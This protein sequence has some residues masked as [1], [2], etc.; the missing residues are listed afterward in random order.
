M[1]LFAKGEKIWEDQHDFAPGTVYA[2]KIEVAET[3]SPDELKVVVLKEDQRELISWQMDK[4]DSADIPEPA[5]AALEPEQIE[6]TELLYLNGLHLEQYRHAT[7]QPTDY[8]REA[9]RRDPEDIRNNTAL[10][11]WLM[12][13]AQFQEAEQH[14]R[15][16]IERWT[17]RNPNPYD[18]E[19]YYFLGICLKMQQRFQEAYQVLYKACWNAAWQNAAYFHLAQI[20]AH[21]Q[22]WEKALEHIE[23]S[24]I[25]NSRHHQARHLKIILLRKLGK[26]EQAFTIVKDSIQ[27]DTFNLGALY[28]KY[29][30]TKD[31]RVLDE[32]LFLIRNH[33]F[34]FAE[35]ALDYALSGCY[36]EAIAILS[37]HQ[38]EYDRPN[39]LLAYYKAWFAHQAGNATEAKTYYAEAAAQSPDFGF[40]NRLEEVMALQQAL[41]INP[42]DYRAH[43]FLGNFFYAFRQHQL[44]ISH[45]EKAAALQDDNPITYRNLALAYFNKTAEPEKALKFLEKAF[46][47]DESSARLLM[48]LDQLYKSLNRSPQERLAFLE[49][50][51]ELVAFRDDLFL[52]RIT[53]FNTLDR[54]E[55]ALD[56]LSSRTFHP[57]EGGEGKVPAQ[58]LYSRIALAYQ[59]I[60]NEQYTQA[61]EHLTLAQEYPENL[62]EGKLFGAQENDIFYWLGCAYK[63][64]NDRK[65]AEEA[66]EKASVGLSE[67]E[68][69]IFYNDQ[70]PDKIFYQG[71][72]LLKLNR[73]EEA[74]CRFHKLISFAE[75]RVT[76]KVKI[77]YFAVSLPDLLLWEEDLQARNTLFCHYL[78]GLGYLG[79]EETEKAKASFQKAQQLDIHHQGVHWHHQM[80][81]AIHAKSH[82]NKF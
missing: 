69:A 34:N 3:L 78:M 44:A 30:L 76:Q 82:S 42:Q 38:T 81:L 64:L 33:S 27:I 56:L 15:K 80:V 43:Y 63:G 25:R 19:A 22:D 40:P 41:K 9:L 35:F 55:K 60:Q 74:H 46:C 31:S 4:S 67:P 54:Y 45:W 1:L 79:L 58:Y 6:S 66:W 2:Q 57:W 20:D 62:G 77:D 71:L 24:L 13:R 28:E 18:G 23:Q 75:E 72:A 61:I 50:Y 59:H 70:Q 39:P 8:Y 68:P 52:E 51:P 37:L 32:F 26:K 7:Y 12:R 10:G 16:A 48:E 29:L 5:K 11:L 53:L 47:M 36:E 17:V 73:Q 49:K 14:F 21:R 65:K